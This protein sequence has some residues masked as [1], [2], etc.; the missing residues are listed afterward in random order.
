M[1]LIQ[2]A[3]DGV[4]FNYPAHYV[5]LGYTVMFAGSVFALARLGPLAVVGELYKDRPIAT[6]ALTLASPFFVA[7]FSLLAMRGMSAAI[8]QAVPGL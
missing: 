6:I 5:A 2:R 3:F 7:W 4:F 8:G 1:D